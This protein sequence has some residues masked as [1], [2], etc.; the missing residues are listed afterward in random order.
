MK[1]KELVAELLKLDQ[2]KEIV[3][4]AWDE[5]D[6]GINVD[7]CV[8]S[9]RIPCKVT[10]SR[11]GGT[12]KSWKTTV[13]FWEDSVDRLSSADLLYERDT[14]IPTTYILIPKNTKD[15]GAIQI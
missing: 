10:H 8:L 5:Y 14:S 9:Y 11:R 3:F 13:E 6:G 7:D 1:V 4:A 15:I 2:E 12:T